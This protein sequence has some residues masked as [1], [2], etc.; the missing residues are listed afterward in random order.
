MCCI[1][2]AA[3]RTDPSLFTFYPV[4]FLLPL[5]LSAL[6][7]YHRAIGGEISDMVLTHGQGQGQGQQTE[8]RKFRRNQRKLLRRGDV[9]VHAASSP[10]HIQDKEQEQEH[11]EKEEEE[12][13]EQE[14][15]REVEPPLFTRYTLPNHLSSYPNHTAYYQQHYGPS[16]SSNEFNNESSKDK[17]LAWILKPHALGCGQGIKVTDWVHG[18]DSTLLTAPLVAQRYISH[19]LLIHGRKIDLR[20]Y[21]MILHSL[22]PVGMEEEMVD[23]ESFTQPSFSSTTSPPLRLYLSRLGLVRFAARPYEYNREK[24]GDNESVYVHLTNN[25]INVG[26]DGGEAGT[27]AHRHGA[28]ENWTL[29]QL[30]AYIASSSS[31]TH[32]KWEYIWS[33]IKHA[34][35]YSIMAAERMV[36]ESTDPSLRYSFELLGMDVLIDVYGIVHI[37]EIN[38]MPDLQCNSMYYRHR[39]EADYQVKSQLLVDVLNKLHF[40]KPAHLQ[41][42]GNAATTTTTIP[43]SASHIDGEQQLQPPFPLWNDEPCEESGFERIL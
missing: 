42:Q 38:S 35:V 12:E 8:Q 37:C 11:R 6:L 31:Y 7:E 24:L 28:N 23:C 41:N 30:R 32:I 5:E 19:P 36:K 43:D 40:D 25:S 13:K 14:E 33:Q 16:V 9:L 39:Y 4:S 3:L 26:D 22:A 34:T 10:S 15:R 18:I 17:Q 1:C 2:S 21:V 20:L 27:A 29:S